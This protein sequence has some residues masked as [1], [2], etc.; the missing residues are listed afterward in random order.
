M[1]T[2]DILNRVHLLLSVWY[3]SCLRGIQVG[4][5]CA[6]ELQQVSFPS[7]AGDAETPGPLMCTHAF[8]PSETGLQVC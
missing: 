4:R 2:E 7:L 6:M 1:S 3:L 8:H 5:W